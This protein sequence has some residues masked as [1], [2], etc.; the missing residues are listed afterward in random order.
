MA[1]KQSEPVPADDIWKFHGEAERLLNR[2]PHGS[3]RRIFKLALEAIYMAGAEGDVHNA[4]VYRDE[5]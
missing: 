5:Q 2:I 3:T 1:S 4:K